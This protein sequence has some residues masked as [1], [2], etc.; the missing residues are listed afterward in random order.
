MKWH[1]S[2]VYYASWI[3]CHDDETHPSMLMWIISWLMQEL[4][5]TSYILWPNI[6]WRKTS[7]MIWNHSFGISSCGQSNL[8]ER[9]FPFRLRC[10]EVIKANAVFMKAVVGE[11]ANGMLGVYEK[12]N[13]N[14]QALKSLF[15]AITDVNDISQGDNHILCAFMIRCV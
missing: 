8:T 5:G 12:K 15:E 2:K 9:H 14:N 7:N 10:S 3:Y 4:F 1:L 11:V 6:C 13:K